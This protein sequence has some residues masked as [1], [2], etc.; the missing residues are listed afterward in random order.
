MSFPPPTLLFPSRSFVVRWLCAAAMTC[1]LIVRADGAN[2]AYLCVVF[3]GALWASDCLGRLR[4]WLG[5]A[6]VPGYA[7][8]A[9]AVVL[10][11]IASVAILGAL[12]SRMAGNPMPTVASAMCVG[13]CTVLGV[14]YAERWGTGRAAAIIAWLAAAFVAVFL[15]TRGHFGVDVDRTLPELWRAVS[16]WGLGGAAL[17]GAGAATVA[18]KRRLD[19]PP[20]RSRGARTMPWLQYRS[21]LVAPKHILVGWYSTTSLAELL[22]PTM[23]LA[24]VVPRYM[25]VEAGGAFAGWEGPIH[26]VVCWWLYV[27][28]LT[29]LMLLKGAGTWLGTAWRLGHGACRASLGCAFAARVT[30][31]TACSFGIA[32]NLVVVHAYLGGVSVPPVSGHL[33][34][35]EEALLVYAAGL[36]A[37]TW[38]FIAH[39]SRTATQP[40]FA[41]PLATATAVDAAV[42][43]LAPETGPAG[44]VVLACVLFGSGALLA[45]GGGRAIARVD[46]VVVKDE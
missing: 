36:L 15:A 18:L 2:W 31:A 29:P 42:F 37:A 5:G 45:L 16:D 27:G 25:S 4:Q 30:W 17:V 8:T 40:D 6:F 12:L 22:I 34:F 35:F 24:V 38:A 32:L 44:L 33:L 46:F 20:E 43:L 28:S 21:F 1:L 19:R 14:V 41:G 23:M 3:V 7:S 39:P 10:A 11:I 9:L 13:M 26:L